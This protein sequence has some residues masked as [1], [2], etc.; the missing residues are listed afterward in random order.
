MLPSGTIADSEKSD[1][2]TAHEIP[3]RNLPVLRE[4]PGGR[5]HGAGAGHDGGCVES[6]TASFP[7]PIV[8]ENPENV[9]AGRG[10]AILVCAIVTS[11]EACGASPESGNTKRLCTLEVIVH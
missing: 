10:G 6:A 1:E 8:V 4:R 9:H 7:H 11:F 3:C 5:S 2:S